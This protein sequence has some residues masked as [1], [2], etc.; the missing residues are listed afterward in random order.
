MTL[1]GLLSAAQFTGTPLL[2]EVNQRDVILN[3]TFLR[4][5]GHGIVGRYNYNLDDYGVSPS[6]ASVS[7]QI[8]A[9]EAIPSKPA[10]LRR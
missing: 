5:S 10:T 6:L 3:V 7:R 9:P 8:R 2:G 4:Y 1:L